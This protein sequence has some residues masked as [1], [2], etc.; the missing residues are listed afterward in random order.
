MQM[1]VVM[2]GATSVKSR[3]SRSGPNRNDRHYTLVTTLLCGEDIRQAQIFNVAN[4]QHG[5]Q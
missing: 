3:D 2:F 4:V 1:K 5:G